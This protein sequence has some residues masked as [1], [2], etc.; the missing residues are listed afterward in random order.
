VRNLSLALNKSNK[1]HAQ[2]PIRQQPLQVDLSWKAQVRN[3][4]PWSYFPARN[5]ENR[6]P[7]HIVD[8]TPS[9][10]VSLRHL[11]EAYESFWANMIPLSPATFSKNASRL[12]LP[13]GI[14]HKNIA[15]VRPCSNLESFRSCPY[16]ANWPG[17]SPHASIAQ[18]PPS[19]LE[20]PR[21]SER[22]RQLHA[23]RSAA[24]R[25]D[26]TLKEDNAILRQPPARSFQRAALISQMGVITTL[27]GRVTR[28]VLDITI[29]ERK[30]RTSLF[31]EFVHR[32]KLKSRQ[33]TSKSRRVLKSAHPP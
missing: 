15:T 10:I 12:K 8:S 18:H 16:R 28:F 24:E 5:L 2:D 4:C 30:F 25:T 22:Y 1:K 21:G 32:P 7:L 11:A 19:I 27:L 23:L 9:Q 14:S 33:R 20:I 31:S 6:C 29:K 13:T 26:T 3:R 17:F